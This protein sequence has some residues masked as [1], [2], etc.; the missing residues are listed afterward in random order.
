MA[1]LYFNVFGAILE[2]SLFVH[3]TDISIFLQICSKLLKAMSFQTKHMMLSPESGFMQWHGLLSSGI[4]CTPS[5]Y[6]VILNFM[7]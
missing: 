3:N 7:Q 2:F 6:L 1:T 4:L 5:N